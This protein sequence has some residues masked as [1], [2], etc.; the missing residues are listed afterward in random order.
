M[1]HCL[2]L[3]YNVPMSASPLGL[4][5]HV[6]RYQISAH[7]SGGLID[8][9][10]KG[11]DP[12]LERPVMVRMFP[13]RL[14]DEA[15]ELVVKQAFYGQ[16]QRAGALTH[17][18]IA[19]LFD[20]GE[21]GPALFMASEFVDATNLADL[22]ASRIELD[23][24]LRVALIAQVVDALEYAR[25]GGVAH[26]Q[27]RPTSVLVGGDFSVKLAGFGVAAVVDALTAATSGL[28]LE[29]SRYTAPERQHG[30]PGDHR[31]DV[32]SLAAIALDLLAD[33]SSV[34]RPAD[35]IPPVPAELAADGIKAERWTA[36]FERALASDPDERFDTPAELEVE[37]L[38]TLGLGA[39]EARVA[40]ETAR[41]D[42]LSLSP[43]TSASSIGAASRDA[44]SF[45]LSG[46]DTTTHTDHETTTRGEGHDETRLSPWQSSD[47]TTAAPTKPTKV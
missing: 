40:R 8:D 35:D 10:Y 43:P 22:L 36:I 42:V 28:V 41:V 39:A 45:Q 9:V 26:L 2:R 31:S 30:L 25:E 3:C 44:A 38:L 16:M 17:H 24:S 5:A 21:W 19:T 27:L 7:L 18:G 20:A 13:L 12:L 46:S 33:A 23:L 11:F 6:G 47:S 15:A 29:P 32:F 4:P 1:T 34:A 14:N 37:L